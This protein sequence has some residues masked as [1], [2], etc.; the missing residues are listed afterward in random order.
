MPNALVLVH[1]GNTSQRLLSALVLLLLGRH[2]AAAPA[3]AVRDA[4]LI[5]AQARKTPAL[6]GELLA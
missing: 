6:K 2:G 4:L 1:N 5:A 3:P